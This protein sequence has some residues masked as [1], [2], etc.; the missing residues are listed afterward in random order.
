MFQED[1]L[2]HKEMKEIN[3]GIFWIK[4]LLHCVSN[5]ATPFSLF[6]EPVHHILYSILLCLIKS[7][8]LVQEYFYGL[9]ND[10][11]PHA[12]VSNFSDLQVFRIGGGPQAPRSALP[13]GAEPTADP[14]RIV[15]VSI[16]R[17]LIHLVLAV[18]GAK[19]P[20]HLLSR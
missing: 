12:S 4:V 16:N 8:L 11:S 6:Q 3:T 1:W 7:F 10:L 2:E 15:P 5:G 13:I 14:T 18:S 9:M 17:D 20:E 19:D